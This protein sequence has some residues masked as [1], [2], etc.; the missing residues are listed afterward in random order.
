MYLN[1]AAKSKILYFTHAQ[2]GCTI[3]VP[4][5]KKGAVRLRPKSV[6]FPGSLPPAVWT[7]IFY[8]LFYFIEISLSG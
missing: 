4:K 5:K 6:T 2:K 8:F 3:S 7:G 1:I